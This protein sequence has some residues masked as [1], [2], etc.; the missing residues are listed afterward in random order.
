MKRRAP[1]TPPDWHRTA[2][3]TAEMCTA[4]G[5][6]AM[7]ESIFQ[8]YEHRLVSAGDESISVH[9]GGAGPPLLLLHGYP[10]NHATWIKLAGPLAKHFTCIIADLPGYGASSIPQDAPEHENFSKRR[11]A[12]LL[13]AAMACMG[14]ADFSVMGHDR[15]AR[16][17]YRM[18]LDHPAVIRRVVIIEIIPTSDM[19]EAFNAE[20]AMKAYHWPFL[21]QPFPLPE[22]LISG[23]PIFYLE[24]TL[25]S[26]VKGHTLDVFDPRSLVS[27]R[28]QMS[29]PARL[30]AMCEDYRA[31]ASVDRRLDLSD[32]ARGA[33]VAA[34]LLFVWSKSGFPSAI[35]DPLSL[36]RPWTENL[37]G[38]E[39][40][41]GHFMPEENPDA[42][43][44]AASL[45]L[46]EQV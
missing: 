19:W 14:H 28:E 8:A 44:A 18:A 40:D 33:R 2:P 5:N 20:I 46:D 26:W 30:H 41:S 36:W 3:P 32:G 42:L 22:T 15:G 38:V 17:A 11:M 31:G 10:Q 27:Y 1:C 13:V 39:I 4:Y 34:P 16:V 45:F 35:G 37:S 43:L 7:A 12:A 21:A 9:V 24:W 6:R 29:D 25:R 23:D